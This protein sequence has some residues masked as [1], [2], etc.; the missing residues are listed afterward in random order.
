MLWTAMTLR[1]ICKE[2]ATEEVFAILD[3]SCVLIM[4]PVYF[5]TDTV[6]RLVSD[7]VVGIA[8]IVSAD[9]IDL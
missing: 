3:A 5:T 7:C 2:A 1:L 4:D 8:T 6:P 9:M